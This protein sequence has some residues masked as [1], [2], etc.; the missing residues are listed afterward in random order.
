MKKNLIALLC[1]LV[2]LV[3]AMVPTLAHAYSMEDVKNIDMSEVVAALKMDLAG[4]RAAGGALKDAAHGLQKS[5]VPY[6]MNVVLTE[7]NAE[8]LTNL[9]ASL[10]AKAI[11]K[12]QEIGK[13]EPQTTEP[14]TEPTEPTKPAEPTEPTEPTEPAEPTGPAQPT[15]QPTTQSKLEQAQ[16]KIKELVAFLQR[17]LYIEIDNPSEV[18]Q[19]IADDSGIDYDVIEGE[20]G[21]YYLHI[22]IENNRQ[23]FNYAVFRDLVDDLVA[24]QNAEMLK[25]PDGNY[26]YVMTYEHIAGELAFH[27]LVWA[28]AKGVMKVTNS[29]NAQLLK[30]Y[31]SAA[32]AD[33][34]ADEDRLPSEVFAIAGIILYN[35]FFFNT[36]RAL[37]LIKS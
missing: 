14:S 32:Q 21:T 31:E 15:T 8:K 35:F 19:Y 5:M 12:I 4:E 1:A 13:P 23:I 20:G 2:L 34:N 9:A 17:N 30:I 33:L 25:D 37:G 22:D 11:A 27:M 18:A 10:M 28:G 26:D 16:K 3:S 24:K 29:Q 6:V 36:L 7:E